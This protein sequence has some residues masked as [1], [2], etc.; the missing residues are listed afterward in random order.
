MRVAVGGLTLAAVAACRTTKTRQIQP[1]EPDAKAAAAA[2]QR[3]DWRAAAERWWAVWLAAPEG[4]ARAC[5]EAARALLELRDAESAGNLLD[6]GIARFPKDPNLVEWK[7]RSLE[8]LGFRRAAEE[9][10]ERALEIEPNRSS[11]LLA[12]GRIRVDLGLETAAVQPLRKFV[13][14]T[15]G[16]ADS[17][18][19]LARALRGSGDMSGSYQ[20]WQRAFTLGKPKVED[21]LY[22]ASLGLDPDVRSA[23]PEAP[24]TSRTWLDLAL[25]LDPMCTR[26]HFQLGLLSH[27]L[28]AYEQAVEHYRRAVE[29]DPSCLMAITNLAI[30]YSG[31][32]NEVETRKMVARALDLEKDTDRRRALQRLLEP[33]EKKADGATEPQ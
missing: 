24:A 33:F 13:A 17:Y 18:A 20:A 28:G 22:A 16:D 11:A 26:A 25:S 4:D 23:H 15:G 3:G 27:E 1:G 30:L 12:L 32:G 29:T 5:A 31:A 7:S 10:L 8:K 9:Y 2:T 14:Q 6:Q 21:L 19:L